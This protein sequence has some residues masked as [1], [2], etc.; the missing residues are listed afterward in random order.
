MLGVIYLFL[1]EKKMIFG[2]F[3]AFYGQRSVVEPGPTPSPW[4]I[5]YHD[6]H[7]Y[8]KRGW[9]SDLQG[10]YGLR[11]NFEWKIII[12]FPKYVKIAV[13]KEPL[14]INLEILLGCKNKYKF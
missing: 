11:R 1:G 12:F 10:D 7:K 8:V 3:S 9:G 6:N 13:S 14:Q 2:C 5:S 4:S